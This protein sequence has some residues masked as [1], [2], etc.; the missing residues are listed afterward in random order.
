MSLIKPSRPH[1]LNTRSPKS[2]D[3]LGLWMFD[4]G[5]GTKSDNIAGILSDTT[6]RAAN[7]TGTNYPEIGNIWKEDDEGTGLGLNRDATGAISDS[8]EHITFDNIAALRNMK[9]GTVL[10][11]FVH[12]ISGS[13]QAVI[14]NVGD[15]TLGSFNGDINN[16]GKF[17]L[18]IIN[19]DTLRVRSGD[20]GG[21]VNGSIVL[22]DDVVYTLV[23]TWNTSGTQVYVDGTLDISTAESFNLNHT[24]LWAFGG[25]RSLDPDE[26]NPSTE[27]NNVFGGILHYLAVYSNQFSSTEANA[28][29]QYP[30][31]LV[32]DLIKVR[33][34]I[35]NDSNLLDTTITDYRVTRL[36]HESVL[37]NVTETQWE[38]TPETNSTF[39]GKF[40]ITTKAE[41][42][43]TTNSGNILD[44]DLRRLDMW[45]PPFQTYNVRIREKQNGTYTAWSPKYPILTRGYETSF[46]RYTIL[47]RAAVTFP[48]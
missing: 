11:R 22:Q 17:G 41:G 34:P 13:R 35:S 18:R 7:S 28:I 30:Y 21:N 40:S 29:T 8:D 43:G 6:S 33:F 24:S 42:V 48:L 44:S 27:V 9:T 15:S 39:S 2:E 26:I 3:I 37:T 5:T 1:T 45:I 19:G 20:L 4:E 31:V 23:M 12:N 16:A 25:E 38:F 10:V 46:D 32:N 47:N 14:S 36:T